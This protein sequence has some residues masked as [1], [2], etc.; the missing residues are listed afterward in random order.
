MTKYRQHL[1]QVRSDIFEAAFDPDIC[2]FATVNDLAAEAGLDWTTVDN[3]YRGVTKR[4]AHKTVF[5]LARAVKMDL[6]L[7]QEALAVG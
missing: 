1:S 6:Q 7:V 2:G 4:P 3:L 5:A